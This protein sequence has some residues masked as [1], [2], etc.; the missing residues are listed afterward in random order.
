MAGSSVPDFGTRIGA[1][2]NSRTAGMPGRRSGYLEGR[3]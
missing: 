2:T 3:G 1:A